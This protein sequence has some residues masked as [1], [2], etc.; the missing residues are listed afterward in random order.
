MRELDRDDL[1]H[2]LDAARAFRYRLDAFVVGAL[3][4]LV[5]T[6]A[7]LASILET[8]SCAVAEAR[9]S[10]VVLLALSLASRVA[11]V[12]RDCA[13]VVVASELALVE[14]TLA[15]GKLVVVQRLLGAALTARRSYG[16]VFAL[17]ASVV[18]LGAALATAHWQHV[19]IAR[20]SATLA[21]LT[22]GWPVAES[23]LVGVARLL[24]MFVCHFV[25]MWRVD[26][27]MR[28]AR[29]AELGDTNMRRVARVAVELSDAH[30]GKV[31]WM[32]G[33]Y[34][35]MLLIGGPVVLVLDAASS[36]RAVQVHGV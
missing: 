9:M 31:A 26:G 6:V 30:A 18:T 13:S 35:P 22:F 11:A 34:A 1:A 10:A 17:P 24:A 8:D 19:E 15:L 2:E 32:L 12:R 4:A 21:A 25:L 27:H 16:V 5:L 20:L 36:R 14:P 33:A 29:V 3:V 23:T 28:A 7:L